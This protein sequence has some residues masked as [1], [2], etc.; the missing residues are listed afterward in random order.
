MLLGIYSVQKFLVTSLLNSFILEMNH[1]KV[2]HTNKIIKSS[3]SLKSYRGLENII[4][5][6]RELLMEK[7]LQNITSEIY[8]GEK[9]HPNS[10]ER[11]S[12]LH[13]EVTDSERRPYSPSEE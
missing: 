11:A 3:H 4:I 8:R 1:F 9:K 7:F 13:R 12:Y 10:S 2:R 6:W 5:W